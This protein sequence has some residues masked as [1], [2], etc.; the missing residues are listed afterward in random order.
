M[1]LNLFHIMA[2]IHIN[3]NTCIRCK[4]CVRICPSAL[5]TLQEDKGIEVN[6][7]DCISCGHCVAVCP[8]NSIEHTDFPAEKVH[9]IDRSQL[10]T[11]DQVELLILSRRSNRAF[12]KEKVSEELLQRIIEAAHRAPTATN[13]QEVKMV[14]VTRPETLKEVSHITIGTFMSI[15]NLVENPLLK[16]ILKPLMPS[17]YRY[18]PV[19][20]RLHEEFERGNDGILRGATAAIFF[21]TDKKERFGCQDCNLAYQNASLMAEAAGVSQ[22]YT[23]FV[24][25][26]AGM[27]RKRKLQKL[28]GI[29]GTVHA[30]IALGM[31]SFRFDKYIDNTLKERLN[32]VINTPFRRMEYTDAIE[33]LKK[34]VEDGHPFENSDIRWG[35]DLQSEHEKY[36]TEQIV[37]GPVFLINYPRE[38]KS[39]YMRDNDDGKTVAACDLLVPGVGELVG[40]SQR[41]ERYDVLKKKMEEAGLDLKEYQWYLDLRKYGGCKHAGFGIGFDRLLMYISGMENIRDVEPFPRTYGRIDY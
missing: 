29:E 11:A 15:V 4:K 9:T 14:L 20:K 26:A 16:M 10:P 12:S 8:S 31:P 1:Y 30:G 21:Y 24:C 28:L 39:Y 27:D 5:F 40:G 38:I 17:G 36:I 18:V 34:A 32:H 33:I 23:G 41:E 35:L 19:F 13:A 37:K 22:F 7:E 6:A 2:Q 25:S 3:Q